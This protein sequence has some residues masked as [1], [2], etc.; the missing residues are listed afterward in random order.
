MFFHHFV[1]YP[2]FPVIAAYPNEFPLRV[3]VTVT[4]VFALFYT[5]ILTQ[6]RRIENASV[7]IFYKKLSS[8]IVNQA[9]F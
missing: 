5:F 7:I 8:V 9:S 4:T 6:N 1:S 3:S 2:Y